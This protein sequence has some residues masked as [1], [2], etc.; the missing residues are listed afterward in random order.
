MA[1]RRMSLG[2][3]R[4]RFDSFPA[5]LGTPFDKLSQNWRSLICGCFGLVAQSAE[6]LAVNQRVA[7]SNPAEPAAVEVC[8][9]TRPS[10]KKKMGDGAILEQDNHFVIHN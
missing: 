8:R 5:Y 6:R 1:V 7:G 10:L 2:I 9:F 3:R 4:K